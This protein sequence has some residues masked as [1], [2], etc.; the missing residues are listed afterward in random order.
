MKNS[1]TRLF[2]GLSGLSLTFAIIKFAAR[3]SFTAPAA[4]APA[5]PT[6]APTAAPEMEMFIGDNDGTTICNAVT[7]DIDCSNNAANTIDVDIFY[8]QR[9]LP[10]C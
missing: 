9:Q 8:D 3:L 2:F 7:L 5:A 1:F 6:F 10:V 4:P